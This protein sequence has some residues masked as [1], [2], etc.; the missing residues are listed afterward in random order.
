MEIKKK[1]TK[2]KI[3]DA[4]EEK[5]TISINPPPRNGNCECCGKN[6]K[7]LKPFG[8]AG[9]PLVGDFDGAL[10]V[11]TFRSMGPKQSKWKV[12]DM[13]IQGRKL[14]KNE[15][16]E[17]DALYN[18]Q[19]IPQLNWKKEVM[20]DIYTIDIKL[21]S[22]AEEKRYRI[23]EKKHNYSFPHLDEEKFIEKYGKQDLEDFWFHEQISGTVSASWECRDCIVLSEEEYFNRK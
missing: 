23:L 7:D 13:M 12:D 14:T 9:D 6:I 18:K 10:L 4:L 8:K 16:K 11:K 1:S 17:H 20:K 21:L 15:K 19:K 22:K 2:E 5:K 3:L